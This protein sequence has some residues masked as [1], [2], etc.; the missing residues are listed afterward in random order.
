MAET[1]IEWVI[2]PDGSRGHTV[3]PIRFKNIET[4]KV[5]HYCEKISAGCANC[6]ASRMQS[7]YLSGL[8]YVA[9]NRSKGSLFLDEA[10]LES[11]QRRRK[12]TGYFW[13][14]MTDLFGDWVPGEWID[15]CLDAMSITPHHRHYVLTKRPERARGLF[16]EQ[17]T[18]RIKPPESMWLGVSVE[19]Q[20]S[21]DERIPHL[22]ATPAAVR[23]LSVEPLL[24]PVSFQWAKWDDGSPH[25]RR[26]KQ[27]PP[28]ESD[29]K[30]IAGCRSHLDGLKMLDWVIVG[31]ESG[32]GA[33]PCELEWIRSIVRQCAEANVPCFVKQLGTAWVRE[34]WEMSHSIGETWAGKKGNNPDH[35]PPDLNVRQ[36]PEVSRG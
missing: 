21:A 26:A 1:K 16:L 29:G 18:R 4:G 36:Y 8:E 2:G 7:P 19:N 3:N 28:V 34:G 20:R 30:I 32:P 14:D 22:L 17:A 12:P 27:V 5:G 13:C 23:F 33:R 6:Y 11:A 35:W 31:G 25:P 15:R 10:V 9:S 24:G